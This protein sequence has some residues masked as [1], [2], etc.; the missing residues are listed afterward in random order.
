MCSASG[1]NGDEVSICSSARLCGQLCSQ[2]FSSLYARSFPRVRMLTSTFP[3]EPELRRSVKSS[4]RW[5]GQLFTAVCVPS[6][7]QHASNR[8]RY[9]DLLSSADSIVRM[10]Q[11]AESLLGRLSHA[12]ARC[13]KSSAKEAATQGS[14]NKQPVTYQLLTMSLQQINLLSGQR[15]RVPTKPSLL[16][17]L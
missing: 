17:P 16:W 6:H 12:R 5:L 15:Q 8:E 2:S 1:L 4:A 9:R 3:V 10:R 7:P 11:S 13:H 14:L